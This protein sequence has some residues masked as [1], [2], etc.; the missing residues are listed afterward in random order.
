MSSTG[1]PQPLLRVVVKRVD[2]VPGLAG[3]CAGFEAG[4]WRYD[5]LAEHMMEW[6][7]E[8]ALNDREFAAL[9]GVNARKALRSAA[10]TIYNS[11]N[12]ATRGE[13]GEILL[14]AI[15]RQEFGS[16]P[17]VSKVFFKDSPNDTVKGFDAVH[18]VEGA[19]G[20]ELW[21]G[22]VKLYQNIVS[23]VRDVVQELHQHTGI[24]YL[25]SEFAAIWRKIGSDHPHRHQLQALIAGNVSM[26][27][28]FKVLCFPILLTYDSDVVAAHRMTD[29]KYEA[30]ISLE[31]EKH[32]DR[33]RRANLPSQ[34]KLILILLP[35]NSKAKLLER[36]DAK[37]K[38]MIT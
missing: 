38:G 1:M 11:S 36:F 26:D 34:I 29:A 14:H 20:L 9:S 12:F 30:A 2:D 33:F 32:H 22:E 27:E 8:F 4:E 15:M 18:V 3:V 5:Q 25:R 24:S 16:I 21:L 19:A 6:L 10:Q 35:M 37:L 23:A 7:P 17:A 13:V 28:V 31:F